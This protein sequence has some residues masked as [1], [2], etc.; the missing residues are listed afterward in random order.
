MLVLVITGCSVASAFS[1][2]ATPS[3]TPLPTE[4]PTPTVTPT[5]TEIPFYVDAK[6]YLENLQVPILI[7]HRFVGDD[8]LETS[9]STKMRYSDFKAQLQSLYDNGYSLVSLQDWM[10]GTFD[11]PIGRKPLIITL[12]DLWFADQL[13]LEDDGT[14]SIYSGIGILWAFSQ[15]HPDFGFSAAGFSNMGDKK[16]ADKHVE[17]YFFISDGDVWMDRLGLTMAWPLITVWSPIITSSIIR[18]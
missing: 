18:S 15:E 9:T 5:A 14:P 17:D 7:Y 10:D 1:P 4:T 13:F 11:V 6:V 8:A 3:L 16:T 2:T 12:D